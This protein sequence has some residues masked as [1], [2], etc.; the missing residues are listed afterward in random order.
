MP[1]SDRRSMPKMSAHPVK[2]PST[3]PVMVPS[4]EINTDSTRTMR[5]TRLSS[6]PTTRSRPSSR[7]RSRIDSDMVLTMPMSATTTLISS[8]PLTASMRKS[9]TCRRPTLSDARCPAVSGDVGPERR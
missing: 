5:R 4:A 6:M 2:T 7:R 9:K 1:A 8:R 3:T